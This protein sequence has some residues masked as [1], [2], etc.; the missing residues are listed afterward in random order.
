MSSLLP[1]RYPAAAV[2]AGLRSNLCGVQWQ[3]SA[4]L[5]DNARLEYGPVALSRNAG[6]LQGALY[7]HFPEGKGG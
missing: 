2:S 5:L 4:R 7:F 3:P 1:S 6:N